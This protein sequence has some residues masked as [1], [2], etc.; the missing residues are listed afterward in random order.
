MIFV[1]SST[2]KQ[3]NPLLTQCPFCPNWQPVHQLNLIYTSLILWLLSKETL[4]NT[5]CNYVRRC[6]E[7]CETSQ[8]FTNSYKV[9]ITLKSVCVCM[10]ER[11][12]VCVCVF[13]CV[14]VCRLLYIFLP[15]VPQLLKLFTSLKLFWVVIRLNIHL[16]YFGRASYLVYQNNM[17]KKERMYT[18]ISQK[19]PSK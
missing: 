8:M 3:Y 17:N 16:V 19:L 1:S 13:V 14:Y 4:T 10:R 7:I 2:E 15:L 11:E 12:R 9:A 5:G 6:F 18:D